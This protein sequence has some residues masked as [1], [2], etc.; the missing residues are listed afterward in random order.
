MRMLCWP[1]RSPLRASS[2]V[3]GGVKRQET[4]R[5]VESFEPQHGLPLK[6]LKCLNPLAFEKRAGLLIPETYDH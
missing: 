3:S 5:R 2:P 1:L 6:P 4:I